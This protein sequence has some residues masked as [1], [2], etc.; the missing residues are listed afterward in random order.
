[1]RLTELA[2]FAFNGAVAKVRREVLAI[3]AAAACAVGAIYQLAGASVLALEP[4]TG[5]AGARLAVAVGFLVVGGIAIAIPRL[6][7]RNRKSLVQQVQAE[8]AVPRHLQ[9]AAIIE[10]LLLGFSLARDPKHKEK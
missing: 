3:V 7:E 5:A 4:Y 8:A 9:L 10:A 2:G 1:M 6:Y